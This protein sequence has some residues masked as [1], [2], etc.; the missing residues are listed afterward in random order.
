MNAIVET[1][2]RIAKKMPDVLFSVRGVK[3]FFL[4]CVVCVFEAGTAFLV[5]IYR[6]LMTATITGAYR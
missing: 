3:T 4:I 5:F 2:S 1:A 6:R